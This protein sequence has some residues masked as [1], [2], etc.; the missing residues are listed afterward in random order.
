MVLF[1]MTQTNPTGADEQTLGRSLTTLSSSA[2]GLSKS[3]ETL[4][5]AMD[6]LQL[7]TE[8]WSD[9][10]RAASESLARAAESFGTTSG[11]RP[12]PT[13]EPASGGFASADD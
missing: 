1:T 9:R 7:S 13:R 3:V 8:R 11:D 2:D 5:R 4:N 6:D 10:Q 12:S